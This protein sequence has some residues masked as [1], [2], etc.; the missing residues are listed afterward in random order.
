MDGWR[1]ADETQR[2]GAQVQGLQVL[3]PIGST[4]CCG[5]TRV[6]F[7]P[8]TTDTAAVPRASLSTITTLRGGKHLFIVPKI[9]LRLLFDK[10]LS[11]AAG[12]G[13]R[14]SC[15]TPYPAAGTALGWLGAEL[16]LLCL[17]L[18]KARLFSSIQPRAL[19]SFEPLNKNKTLPCQKRAVMSPGCSICV[20]MH[21]CILTPSS[22]ALGCTPPFSAVLGISA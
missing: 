12:A 20:C 15:P 4:R 7:I 14:A 10:H 6:G 3:V 16:N 19:W 9:M 17:S 2:W 5:C 1:D 21:A 22:Q 13:A 18:P 8:Q 11:L